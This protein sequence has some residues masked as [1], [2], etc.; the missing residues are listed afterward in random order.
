MVATQ[1][2]QARPWRL[3]ARARKATLVV[4]LVSG[5]GWLGVDAVLLVLSL[6]AFTSDDPVTVAACYR[7]MGFFVVPALLTAGLL[8]LGS[9]VLLGLG[10]RYGLLR[11]W[12]VAVKLGIN[13]VLTSLVPILLWPRVDEAAALARENPTGL[14]TASL[15]RLPVDLLFPPLVSG[16]ALIVAIVLAVYKPWGLIRP[17]SRTSGG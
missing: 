7:A 9:G 10:T 16:T 3:S 11:Y 17:A 14:D 5:V 1:A 6:T 8:C 15:G 12:W 13:V 2:R 4:H